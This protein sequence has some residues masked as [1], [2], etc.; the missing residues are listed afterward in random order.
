MVFTF[1]VSPGTRCGLEHGGA[2][3]VIVEADADIDE[4]IPAMIKGGFYHAGQVCVSVQ[5]IFVH[6]NI[7]DGVAAQITAGAKKTNCWR[8]P[9]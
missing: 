3:P 4:L 6:E 9:G 5:R 1:E 2:A 7:I 8:S